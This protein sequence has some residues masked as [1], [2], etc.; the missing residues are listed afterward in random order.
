MHHACNNFPIFVKFINYADYLKLLKPQYPAT[1]QQGITFG[2]PH[3]QQ[4]NAE[5]QGSISWRWAQQQAPRYAKEEGITFRLPQQESAEKQWISWKL[6]QQQAPKDA[7]EE[8]ITFTY[9]Y[10]RHTQQAKEES[11]T[12]DLPYYNYAKQE[13]ITFTY[14]QN[15]QSS[16]KEQGFTVQLPQ[17]QGIRLPVGPLGKEQGIT[18][19]YPQT[20]RVY[21]APYYGNSWYNNSQQKS[22][23][24][25]E[26][27]SITVS[28]RQQLNK[29]NAAIQGAV[30]CLH[31][32]LIIIIITWT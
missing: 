28:W 13:G 18:F 4:K 2:L 23:N 12:M 24:A 8:G 29:L 25:N 9:P 7:N 15:E 19:S 20:Q 22:S 21:G 1:E 30:G 14:P 6:A 17:Q 11:I 16:A 10:N 27:G 31:V 5:K 26:Q 3:W 32:P